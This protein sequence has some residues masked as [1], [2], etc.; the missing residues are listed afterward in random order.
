M[1][2]YEQIKIH[3]AAGMSVAEIALQYGTTE[4]EIQ[5]ILDWGDEQV[6]ITILA[7]YWDENVVE[8]VIK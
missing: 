4:S 5:A 3:I 6:A 2:T 7:D 8:N 1:P